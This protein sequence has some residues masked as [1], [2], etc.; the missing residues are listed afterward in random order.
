MLRAF[1]KLSEPARLVI[2]GAGP[3][4]QALELLAK[5]H[6]IDGQVRFLGYVPDVS[7]W[8][9]AA[10]GFLLTSRWEGL[11]M[12]VFEAAAC[13]LA[14]IATR[15]SGTCEAIEDGVTGLLAE[16]GDYAGLAD[17][18]NRLMTMPVEER[19]E[20]GARGRQ[21][22]IEQFS[23]EAA[24]DRHEALYRELL[25]AKVRTADGPGDA[26]AG[27]ARIRHNLAE[28]LHKVQARR[29]EFGERFLD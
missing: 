3:Q 1:A 11:P 6:G 12:A 26:A 25:A 28:P 20:M 8:M 2:A 22:V 21:R 14:Q 18:M 10:D 24:L 27:E 7:P 17:A 19:K 16:P 4:K 29:R 5:R 15:V 23:L 9:R 13:E